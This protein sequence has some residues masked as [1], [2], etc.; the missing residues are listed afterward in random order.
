VLLAPILQAVWIK[1]MENVGEG[2]YE[3]DMELRPEQARR[4][5]DGSVVYGSVQ[6]QWPGVI[7]Y[8]LSSEMSRDRN[9]VAQIEAAIA[10]YHKFTCLKFKKRTNERAYIYFRDGRGCLSP[11]GYSGRVNH[12][13]LARNCRR[14]GT[15]MHE[16]GHSI[17]FYH[18]QSRPDRDNYITVHYGNILSNLAYAFNKHSSINSL[19][20]PYDFSSMMHYG[21][22]AFSKNRQKTITTNDPAN[23]RLIGQ[24]RGFSSTDIKQINLLYKCD[25]FSPPPQTAPPCVDHHRRC[26]EWADRGE[27][28]KN[29]R[30]ML[31]WC[32]K[33]CKVCSA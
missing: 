19:G 20:T 33:A 3:G 12:I 17:G 11:V 16:I 8:A 10:D 6:R 32:K 31:R 28:K 30:Y 26:Q 27:C 9:A 1:E 14:K 18:E 21:A 7:P 13:Q 15:I 5:K 25:G 24:R 22:Y 23:Q 29:P 2:I 4:M